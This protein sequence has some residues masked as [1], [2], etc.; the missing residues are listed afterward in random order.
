MN[1]FSMQL[2]LRNFLSISS[3]SYRHHSHF[4]A[5]LSVGRHTV[6]LISAKCTMNKTANAPF[7]KDAKQTS[8]VT[9]CQMRP[10]PLSPS[11]TTGPP[12]HHLPPSS[13]LLT[14]RHHQFDPSY[15]SGVFEDSKKT[16]C[17]RTDRPTDGQM[18]GRTDGPT[19][20]LIEM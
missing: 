8:L 13:S 11:I 7:Y 5:V 10:H 2:P 1:Q 19:D 18:D 20:P 9:K 6:F 17:G 4:F 16:R 3:L 15:L 12:H 14:P